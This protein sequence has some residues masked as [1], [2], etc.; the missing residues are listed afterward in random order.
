MTLNRLLGLHASISVH[1][2][3]RFYNRNLN[4][5]E[6]NFEMFHERVG[7]HIDRVQN[8]YLAYTLLLRAVKKMKT[9]MELVNLG[10]QPTEAAQAKQL[11][12]NFYKSLPKY[13]KGFDSKLFA[14]SPVQVKYTKFKIFA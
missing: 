9:K 3:D 7:M 8:I 1:L 4:R 2:S 12:D 14:I 6:S 11:V 5:W 13:P 10:V